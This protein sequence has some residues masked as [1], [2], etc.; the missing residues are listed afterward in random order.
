MSATTPTGC[1]GVSNTTTPSSAASAAAVEPTTATASHSPMQAACAALKRY[2]YANDIVRGEDIAAGAT[3][4]VCKAILCGTQPVAIKL[5][6]CVPGEELPNDFWIE[7]EALSKL[8]SPDIVKIF[9]YCITPPCLIIELMDCSLWDIIHVKKQLI[10]DDKQFKVAYSIA[11]ALGA[12]HK[13]SITHRDLKSKNVLV[14]VDFS[15]V[16]LCDLGLSRVMSEQSIAATLCGTWQW[17]APELRSATAAK[18][19]YNN[20]VDIFSYGVVVYEVIEGKLPSAETLLFHRARGFWRDLISQCTQKNP[21][22]RPSINQIID[23]LFVEHASKPTFMAELAARDTPAIRSILRAIPK[24]TKHPDVITNACSAL[25]KICSESDDKRIQARKQGAI[26]IV[27][28]LLTSHST[29]PSVCG[30][31]CALLQQLSKNSENEVLIVQ[32]GGVPPIV[33]VLRTHAACAIVCEAACA[34][35]RNLTYNNPENKSIVVGAGVVP[36]IVAALI[37]HTN[38][39]SLCEA[40][41]RALCHLTSNS[42]ENR[43]I[44]SKAGAI[45]AVTF[46]LKTHLKQ[47]TVCSAALWAL[48]NLTF[49]NSVNVALVVDVGAIPAIVSTLTTHILTVRVCVAACGALRNLACNDDN[50]DLIVEAGGIEAIINALKHHSTSSELCKSACGALQTLW[51]HVSKV[52]EMFEASRISLDKLALDTNSRTNFQVFM[53][54]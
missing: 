3:G 45:P 49:N 32:Q 7:A 21:S 50:E 26:P 33:S 17:M 19:S 14:S 20:K 48:C 23:E 11:L 27:I 15:I 22:D 40:A 39:P 1:P 16:K 36:L 53:R 30:A 37:A 38:S 12:M 13:A 25:T 47:P 51:S 5:L 43:V 52:R 44:V 18:T 54:L 29:S 10:P 6:K 31:A 42:S 8:R 9:G 28:S 2:D 41:C 35:I 34:A 46:V 4:V 24:Y